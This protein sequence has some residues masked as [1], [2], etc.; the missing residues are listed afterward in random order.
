MVDYNFYAL[1]L[2][3]IAGLLTGRLIQWI[4]PK[5]ATMLPGLPILGNV[6]ALGRIGVAF[7]DKARKTV[8]D[9]LMCGFMAI[10]A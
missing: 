4:F 3:L 8:G 1:F 10:T 6:I 7:I 5:D 9:D 2:W